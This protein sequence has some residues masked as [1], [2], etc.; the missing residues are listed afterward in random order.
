VVACV[1]VLPDDL[2]RGVDAKRL[3]V[4]VGR[5]IIEGGVGIDWHDAGSSL[6]VLLAEKSIGSRADIK[7]S[8]GLRNAARTAG[9]ALGSQPWQRIRCSQRRSR[10]GL[11]E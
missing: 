2:A 6:I 7:P 11:D 9:I 8:L 4:V 3:G 1:D 5:G 10:I